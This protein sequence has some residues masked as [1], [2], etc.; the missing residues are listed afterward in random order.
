MILRQDLKNWNKSK[1][2][3]MF[4]TPMFF[5]EDN[6]NFA[7]TIFLLVSVINLM[8]MPKHCVWLSF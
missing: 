5:S 8:H 4:Y 3:T 1:A 6:E 7:G 2:A